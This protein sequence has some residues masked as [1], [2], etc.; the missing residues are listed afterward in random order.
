MTLLS[1]IITH[2]SLYPQGLQSGM[3]FEELVE[4]QLSQS[5]LLPPASLHR[6]RTTFLKKGQGIARFGMKR[7]RI[8]TKRRKRAPGVKQGW[9][10]VSELHAPKPDTVPHPPALSRLP[11]T[12]GETPPPSHYQRV[13]A[14]SQYISRGQEELSGSNESIPQV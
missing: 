10:A 8:G 14:G 2:L 6:P 1:V 13:L 3:S 12:S 5:A 7:F 11:P 4:N 9:E